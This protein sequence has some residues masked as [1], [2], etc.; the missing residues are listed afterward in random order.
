MQAKQPVLACTDPNTD[1]GKV[2]TDGGFGWWCESD[3]AEVFCR[4]AALVAQE[5]LAS[6]GSVALAYLTAHYTAG[7]GYEMIKRR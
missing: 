7:R 5:D 6:M 3:D 2:I 1:V 4:E